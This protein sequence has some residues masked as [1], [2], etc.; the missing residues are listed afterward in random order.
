MCEV[1]LH[2]SIDF[3]FSNKLVMLSIF[4]VLHGHLYIFLGEMFIQVFC[5]FF[6]WVVLSFYFY[7]YFYFLLL[8]CISCFYSLEIKPLSV[9]SFETVFS[10]SIDGLFCLFV[11]LVFLG[12]YLQHM[13]DLR[14]GV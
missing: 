8:S 9:V 4:H 13:E 14:L 5:P 10:Y 6:K 11:C 1:V 7:F 2:S 12:L 3:N